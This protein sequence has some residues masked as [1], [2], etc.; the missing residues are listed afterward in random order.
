MAPQP[1]ESREPEPRRPEPSQPST[2]QEEEG[3]VFPERWTDPGDSPREPSPW[4]G[5]PRGSSRGWPPREV[6]EDEPPEH[7]EQVREARPWPARQGRLPRASCAE[8]PPWRA[9]RQERALQDEEERP[10]ARTQGRP[11]RAPCAEALRRGQQARRAE[12][13]RRARQAGRRARRAGRRARG[14]REGRGAC[15]GRGVETS[16]ITLRPRREG[17]RCGQ[18]AGSAGWLPWTAGCRPRT[19]PRTA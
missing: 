6:P 10:R 5:C 16:A 7:R 3:A 11:P 4:G 12:A 9:A 19:C 15:S 17:L 2:P 18:R 8:A 14:L 1:P 13:R